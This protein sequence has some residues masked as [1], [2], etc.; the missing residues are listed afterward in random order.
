M[1]RFAN[2]EHVPFFLALEGSTAEDSTRSAV[3]PCFD[4]DN[5]TIGF[6]LNGA[7]GEFGM[8][9]LAFSNVTVEG[10]LFPVASVNS[11]EQLQFNF[12]A[13]PLRFGPPKGYK[14]D[15]EA[16]RDAK[17]AKAAQPTQP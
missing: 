3:A 13:T 6:T 11:S 17:K 7:G 5:R 12:G 10:G 4:L 2:A 16:V 8:G 14:P 15:I 9:T 1:A